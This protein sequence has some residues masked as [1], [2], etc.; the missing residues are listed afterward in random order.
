M[1]RAERLEYLRLL[2]ERD[3][4]RRYNL[5]DQL[6]P[7]GGK[8]SRNAY[9]KH[10]EFFRAGAFHKERLFMAGNRVGKTVAGGGE[11]TYHLTGLY[12]DW[13]EGRRFD[14]AIT[15]LAAG[16]TSQTT[17]DIIQSKLLGGLYG[18]PEFGTGL[19]PLHLLGKPTP[20]RGV[21]NLYEEIMVKHT[22]GFWSRLML[23]SYDQGRR[24]F[25]GTEQDVVWL[26]EEVPKDVYDE[27][28]VR[29]MTTRGI[30]MMTFTP[31][32]GL[33]ELVVSFL[34]SMHEQEPL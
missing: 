21:A 17:R 16:D 30:V 33:T 12:P 20:A 32:S 19:V 26:D 15:A 24:I 7:E 8:L 23:R 9:P 18:T 4:R 28:L 2:E 29:T 1:T 22:S 11:M 5:I 10:M 27:A 31:L 34:E 3:R 6:F 13:W 25:Q 14:R